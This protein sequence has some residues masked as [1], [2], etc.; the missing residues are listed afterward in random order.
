ML[1]RYFS[2]FLV[3]MDRD[4][5]EDNDQESATENTTKKFAPKNCLPVIILKKDQ[6]WSVFLTDIV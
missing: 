4:F 2:Y 5:I 3:S 1:L 6:G